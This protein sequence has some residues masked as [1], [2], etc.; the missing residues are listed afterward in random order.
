MTFYKTRI[1]MDYNLLENYVRNVL[2]ITDCSPYGRWASISGTCFLVKYQDNYFAVTARHV[3]HEF[4]V[5]NIRVLL[6]PYSSDESKRQRAL[7]FEQAFCFNSDPGD[8]NYDSDCDDFCILKVHPREPKFLLDPF[9]FPYSR[10]S[11]KDINRD[12]RL[13]VAGY[14]TCE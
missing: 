5:D 3:F 14:P 2:F 12:S 4:L 13:I 7:C 8:S 9:F 6:D 1:I 11:C 10:P